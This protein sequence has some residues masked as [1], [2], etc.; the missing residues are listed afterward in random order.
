MIEVVLN[1]LFATSRTTC[2]T[3]VGTVSSPAKLGLVHHALMVVQRAFRAVL[4]SLTG[5]RHSSNDGVDS[6]PNIYVGAVCHQRDLV[7]GR[8]LVFSQWA[9]LRKKWER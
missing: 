2:Q 5:R 1:D 3:N 7:A 4:T 8:E 9:S 6:G